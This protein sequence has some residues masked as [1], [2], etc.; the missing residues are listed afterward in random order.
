MKL[1]TLC[2]ILL[3]LSAACGDS[4]PPPTEPAIIE[5]AS[6][7]ISP[8]AFPATPAPSSTPVPPTATPVPPT[9]EPKLSIDPGTYK[10]G[11]EIQ[12]GVYAGLAGENILRS[13]N[14]SRLSGVSGNMDDILA[15]EIV[16]GPVLC[17]R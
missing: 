3:A 11:T 2:V 15:I 4:Q 12:P 6:E 16:N 5:D 8:T 1:V 17:R 7:S 14:W 10:V 9:P 13:C